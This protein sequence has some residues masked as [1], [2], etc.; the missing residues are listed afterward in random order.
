MSRPRSP[1]LTDAEARVMSVLWQRHTASVADVVAALK[2]KRAVTYSTVQTILRILEAKGYVSHE[3]VARAFIYRPRVDERQARRQALKHL[4]SR[5]FNGS[6]SLLVLNV[7][8]DEQIDA[9]ELSRL[10]KLIEDA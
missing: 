4:V 2:R 10:K 1:A 9:D 7:L 5:L 8:E 6:P 3:K